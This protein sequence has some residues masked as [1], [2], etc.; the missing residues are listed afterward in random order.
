MAGLSAQADVEARVIETVASFLKLTP[1]R[2]K[3]EHGVGDFPQWDSLAHISVLNEI[4]AAFGLS[5]DI[6]D[7]VSIQTIA[8]MIDIVT[9]RSGEPE[10]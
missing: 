3:P 6:E 4:E 8:D 1:S 7:I 10:P 2:L 5:F 9:E